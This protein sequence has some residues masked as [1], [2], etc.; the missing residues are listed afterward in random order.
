MRKTILTFAMM[1]MMALSATAG[2]IVKATPASKANVEFKGDS[3]VV[4][5][6]DQSVTVSGLPEMQKV[7][8]K[9]NAALDDTLTA[10]GTTVEIGDRKGELDPED[11][12]EISN[13]WAS[14]AKQW[15]ISGSFCLLGLVALVL[16]FRF[17]NRR[18]K[19]R[20]IE[21]AIENNYPLNEFSLN[22][23]KRS[24]IYVQQP[25]VTAAPPVQ[26]GQVPVG[27]PISGQTPD[28]PIVMTDMVNWRALMPAV[29]WIGW[30]IV[31]I[32]FSVAIGDAENPFWPIGLA[33]VVVGL[34]KGFILYKEQKALQEAWKRGQQMHPHSTPMREGI[35]M[36]PS[37]DQDYK[38]DDN[39]PYQ[40]Y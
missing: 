2:P 10:G 32:L 8:D 27:T 39:T 7:R 34:C 26:P 25:V 35:P 23:T 24:A 15:A 29:K 30:G 28:N 14:V 5:D 3:I 33:L 19:Y 6:G 31:L 21:K 16:F 20:V 22:D 11:I 17:L 13:Q 37:F 38:E 12:K 18:N 1:L 9:I 40:P 36:P 4:T